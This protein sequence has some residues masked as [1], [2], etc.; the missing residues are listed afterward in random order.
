M[1]TNEH[2]NWMQSYNT[3]F[4]N[5]SVMLFYGILLMLLLLL[6]LM[7]TQEIDQRLEYVYLTQK[8]ISF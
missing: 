3:K 2:I 1:A 4:F 7:L 8:G 5:Y 6:L